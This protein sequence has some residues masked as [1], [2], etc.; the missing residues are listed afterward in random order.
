[1]AAAGRDDGVGGQPLRRN[2]DAQHDLALQP[3]LACRAGIAGPLRT[4]SR[5]VE[6]ARA[7]P[8]LATTPRSAR[9]CKAETSTADRD[10]IAG[11]HAAAPFRLRN[12]PPPV[13]HG[14]V[15]AGQAFAASIR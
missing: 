13:C 6:L 1:M 5:I 9:C 11:D 7:K 10:G 4:L 2:P 15:D 8:G 12:D 3:A 14:E